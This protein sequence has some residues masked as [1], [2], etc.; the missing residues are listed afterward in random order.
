MGS[1]FIRHLYYKYPSY[2]IFNLDLLTYAGN[3]ENL[4]DI[5][6]C[7]QKEKKKRYFFLKGDIGKRMLLN[8]LFSQYDFSAVV[9]FAA[10]SH[11]DR[12]II[13]AVE[14]IRTNVQGAYILLDTVYQ[15]KIPRFVYISTDEVYG[16]ISL[17]ERSKETSP[18]APTNPYAASKA[19]ADLMVQSYIKTHKLPA[20]I[21]RSS[22]NYGSYQYPEKLH[23]LVITNFL[24][25]KKIPVHGRGN[26]VR[27]WLHVSDFCR[28][29]DL[30]LH[31]GRN[32]SIYNAAGEE[33]ST[34]EVIK[35]IARILGKDLKKYLKYVHDRPG[36]DFRYAPD[37][38]KIKRELGFKREHS[39]EHSLK[40]LVDWYVKNK[41]WW[42]KIKQKKEFQ[43]HYQKQISG[44]YTF[45][46]TK[47]YQRRWTTNK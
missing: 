35:G 28:A 18:L 45:E 22:N 6:A 47:G 40:D 15:H 46:E 37:D 20:L 39:Y 26:Q 27:S 42:L 29:L 12:S 32:F 10:E 24:E 31:K 33:R 3:L 38:S 16:D 41:N 13:N 14:F 36:V 7:E 5:I 19:S 1:H 44:Y 2:Q 30:V 34:L 9:N 11:V 25:G 43:D 17:G 8:K 21:L 4:A 23:P